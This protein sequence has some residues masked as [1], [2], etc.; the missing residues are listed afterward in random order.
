VYNSGF[1]N[2]NSDFLAVGQQRDLFNWKP[3]T[4]FWVCSTALDP[5]NF[6]AYVLGVNTPQLLCHTQFY[7]PCSSLT[8]RRT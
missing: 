6:M 7:C 3:R 5:P 4:W 1:V 8:L 2:H